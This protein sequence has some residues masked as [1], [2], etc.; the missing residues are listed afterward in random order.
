[1]YCKKTVLH[2]DIRLV[3]ELR[4]MLKNR[5]DWIELAT[6]GDKVETRPA[7]VE[8]WSRSADNPIGGWYG[9]QKGFK[10]RFRMYIPPFLQIL[11][12]HLL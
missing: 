10:S 2:C 3:E 1:M 4:N 6:K 12:P 7:I 11:G 5:G 9:L 8:Q